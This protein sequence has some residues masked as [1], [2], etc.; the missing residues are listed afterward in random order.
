MKKTQSAGGIVLSSKGLILVVN[1]KGT[2]WSLPKGHIENNETPIEAAK[3]EIYEESGINELELI[4]ELSTYQ[5]HKIG[6][7]EDEDKTELKTIQMFLFKTT[8][9]NLKPIDPHNP[10]ARWVP[11]DKVENLL[12]HKKDKEFFLNHINEI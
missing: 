9:E 7:R 5:R 11:K 6:L 1:Q 12:T 8:Q 3:R 4:K 2:S 10:E